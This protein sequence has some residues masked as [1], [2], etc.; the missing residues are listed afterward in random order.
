MNK[1][2]LDSRRASPATWRNLVL[3]LSLVG[4]V[5]LCFSP[6]L[7]GDFLWDDDLHIT[8]NPTIVGPLGLNEIWTTAAANYF[9]L[10]LTN[11]W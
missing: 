8:A 4:A 9:P 10:V 2:S 11:F 1:L 3:G 6:A 5:I 7:P